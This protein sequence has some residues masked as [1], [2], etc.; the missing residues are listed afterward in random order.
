MSWMAGTS[1]EEI[2]AQEQARVDAQAARINMLR[3]CEQLRRAVEGTAL[4]GLL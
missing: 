4:E 2:T 3:L 1:A